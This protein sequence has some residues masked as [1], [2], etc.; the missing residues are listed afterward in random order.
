MFPC[1]V[2]GCIAVVKV[3]GDLCAAHYD[4]CGLCG[5]PRRRHPV[6]YVGDGRDVPQTVCYEFQH[7]GMEPPKREPVEAEERR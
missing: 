5:H 3:E 6:V 2:K 4:R 1:R 7:E